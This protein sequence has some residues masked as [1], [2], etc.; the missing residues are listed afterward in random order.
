VNTNQIYEETLVKNLLNIALLT[1]LASASIVPFS[2]IANAEQVSAN[3]SGEIT[4]VTNLDLSVGDAIEMDLVGYTDFSDFDKVS[5]STSST[6]GHLVQST[7]PASQ[8][9]LQV[10]EDYAAAQGLNLGPVET[11]YSLMVMNDDSGYTQATAHSRIPIGKFNI[12]AVGTSNKVCNIQYNLTFENGEFSNGAATLTIMQHSTVRN[13]GVAT[14]R[15]GIDHTYGASW[16]TAE[17]SARMK[18]T[19]VSF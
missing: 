6:S 2:N 8:A 11:S 7:V 12:D 18:V 5:E 3:A 1:F 14:D 13:F 4:N 19:N 10:C 9:G 15:N 16:G 17:M